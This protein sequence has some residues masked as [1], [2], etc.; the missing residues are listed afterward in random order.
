MASLPIADVLKPLFAHL[1]RE[2]NALVIAP[3]GAGKSTVLPQKLLGEPWAQEKQIILLQPRRVAVR[4]I[5]SRIAQLLGTSVG[6]RVG[7][8]MRDEA[9]VSKDTQLLVMTE[10]VLRRRIL[11][12]PELSD[13]AAILFDEYHERSLDADICLALSRDIQYALRPDLKLIVMSATLN[14][15]AI[16]GALPSFHVFQSDGRSY[17]I[18]T[19]YLPPRPNDQLSQS[20]VRAVSVALQAHDGN[21]LCF[22]PGQADIQRAH[23]LLVNSLGDDV[24][25]AR[26]FGAQ[27]DAQQKST[28]DAGDAGLR[29]VILATDIA[30]TSLTV[31]GVHCVVDSGLRRMPQYDIRTGLTALTRTQAAADR[32]DQRRGRAG[33]TAPGLCIRLW[34]QQATRA[35]PAMSTPD[36]ETQ[37]LT[38]L[39]LACA[40][41]GASH[42]A[43]LPW[44]SPPREKSVQA[45][46]DRLKQLALLDH[47]GGV[48]PAGRLAARLPMPADLAALLI[49]AYDTTAAQDAALLCAIVSDSGTRSSGCID[50][51]ERVH[52]LSLAR[53]EKARRL[54]T[55][56]RRWLKDIAAAGLTQKDRDGAMT[57]NP[58]LML[59]RMRPQLLAKR[60]SDKPGSFK[61]AAGRGAFLE[62][63]PQLEKARYLVVGDGLLA[64]NDVRITSAW[65]LSSAE[66]EDGLSDLFQTSKTLLE[67]DKTGRLNAQE[68]VRI[69]AL[70]ISS[71]QI[72]MPKGA[73]LAAI[74]FNM[75]IER[76]LSTLP[77]PQAFTAL[78]QRCAFARSLGEDAPDLSEDGLM[79][80]ADIWLKPLLSDMGS[81][82]DLRPQSLFDAVLGLQD[83]QAIRALE[84]FAPT[85]F[86]LPTGTKAQID[87]TAQPAPS[88]SAKLQAF[89]GARDH[90]TIAGGRVPLMVTLLSPAGRPLQ[91]TQD[92]PG[93]WRGNYDAVRR[94]MRGRYPKHPWPDDPTTAAPTLKT[95]AGIKNNR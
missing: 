29:K 58:G 41:W 45:A 59:A 79:Q 27:S 24:Q 94:E 19:R 10:G 67:S 34:P 89:F 55:R 3:P 81:L 56:A 28:L 48:T 76:G 20:V 65:P 64:G 73:E 92:L 1:T 39:V 30:E 51:E 40:D 7:Y 13:I 14:V 69:G 52:R 90:P 15:D 18:E 66:V 54:A 9:R 11:G 49:S 88:V 35:I 53:D 72:P 86:T 12:D 42:I 23:D 5:A 74:L 84:D 6:G 16:S 70:T 77:W 43:S 22:L 46:M 26:L 50:L 8:Q 80:E 2:T 17:P 62:G 95:K 21:I 33:R 38:D 68:T 37:D 25:I 63:A 85:H 4:A 75:A 91:S 31:P 87:Y 60:R 82:S 44:T 78:R 47:S 36:I 83:Y 32:L 93:F 71:Q 57:D 61:L